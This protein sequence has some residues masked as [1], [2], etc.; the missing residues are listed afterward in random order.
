MAKQKLNDYDK[1]HENRFKLSI[2]YLK[3]FAKDGANIL[4]CGEAS[5]LTVLL[6]DFGKVTTTATDIRI[7]L[8]KGKY[9]V[10]VATE[11]L[12]H[13]KDIFDPELDFTKLSE[14]QYSGVLN[15]LS[16]CKDSLTKDGIIFISTP[17]VNTYKCIA[18]LLYGDNPFMYEP[19]VREMS[20][21]EITNCI[22]KVGLTITDCTFIDV[23]NSHGIDEWF[24]KEVDLLAAKANGTA[25]REDNIFMILKK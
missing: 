24:K 17:N 5:G 18:N 19:H 25:R 15:F 9:N 22:K 14:W 11:I 23:W 21:N 1:A 16:L 8:P 12:E 13:L 20:I 7:E 3:R 10:I 2:E 6:K 4:E